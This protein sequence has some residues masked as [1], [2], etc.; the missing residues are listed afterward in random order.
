[1]KKYYFSYKGRWRLVN[2]VFAKNLKKLM[3]QLKISNAQLAKALNVD[4]SLVSRWLKG[5]C[6]E[7][8][9][10][11]HAMAIEEF[12][13]RRKLSPE[14]KAWLS[15]EIGKPLFTGTTIVSTGCIANWLYP[16]DAYSEYIS[17][18]NDF[19]NLLLVDSFHSLVEKKSIQE[20]AVQ[21]QVFAACEGTD[22][23]A[24][25]LQDELNGIEPGT[26]ID[27]YL[28]S[29]S[30]AAAVDRNILAV[31]SA[32][33][34]R[35]KLSVHMLVETSNN[36]R[37]ASRLISAYMPLLVQGQLTFSVIQGTPQTFT[38]SMNIVI[39]ERAAVIVTEAVQRHATAVGTVIHNRDIVRDMADSFESSSRYA[40]PMMT[41]YN[42]SFAR[43]I[44]E[45]F[46]EEYGVPGSLDVIISGM[47]P[48]YVT[49]EQY[50]KILHEY[51]HP[52]EQFIWRYSEFV[53]FKAAMDEVLKTSRFREVLSL[54]KLRE[55]AET[56]QC[57]MPSMYFMEAGTTYLDEEDCVNIF[58]GYI[59]Y[60]E[61][62]PDFHV[63]LLEDEQLFIPNSCWHIKNNKHIMIHSW[64]I[65]EPM[66]VYSDQ[67][68]LIEEFQ[69]HFDSLWAQTDGGHSR[70]H[71]IEVLTALRNQCAE[72]MEE[73][74]AHE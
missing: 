52:E 44:I 8:R 10:A 23:I 21:N 38:I 64:N 34:D 40:R 5:G 54:T 36:S 35:S 68:M 9:G 32:A 56:G 13:L 67:L 42:D 74:A 66:M 15:S 50:A 29:E 28:S 1:M 49:L 43:N 57:R 16:S 37:M 48:M 7:R 70:S 73:G 65:D 69:R 3:T 46:F 30:S 6:G 22:K 2:T 55:I 11:E 51:G 26:V 58:D 12:V 18:D 17:T 62:I 60:L 31:L 19:P 61:T 45:I 14:N 72:H 33:V 20:T 71:V 24:S 63:V 41:A 27:I 4:P 39:P 59:H 53:R 47:N 25:L